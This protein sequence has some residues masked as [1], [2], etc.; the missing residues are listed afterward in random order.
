MLSLIEWDYPLWAL[1]LSIA[2]NRLG[3]RISINGMLSSDMTA[4][5]GIT[6]GTA[7]ATAELR[8]LLLTALDNVVRAFPALPLFFSCTLTT[9]SWLPWAHSRA[10]HADTRAPARGHVV[11]SVRHQV[12]GHRVFP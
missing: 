12:R 7:F 9:C 2:A 1:R 6:A 11:G 10:R 3:R 4:C 8:L 5:R